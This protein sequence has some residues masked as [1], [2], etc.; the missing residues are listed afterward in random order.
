MSRSQLRPKNW[1]CPGSVSAKDEEQGGL[2]EGGEEDQHDLHAEDH[3]RAQEDVAEYPRR[4]EV[5]DGDLPGLC[6]HSPHL[7]LPVLAGRG[8]TALQILHEAK[9]KED[10]DHD[11]FSP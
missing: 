1:S 3:N 8:K 9:G 6:R 7:R 10:S 5:Q 4:T 2:G 11:I